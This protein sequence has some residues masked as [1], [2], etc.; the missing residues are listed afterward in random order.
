MTIALPRL[1]V[2]EVA[3]CT[4]ASRA[5]R[6]ATCVEEGDVGIEKGQAWVL[7]DVDAPSIANPGCPAE[8]VDGER[9]RDRLIGLH[10]RR[11]WQARSQRKGPGEHHARGRPRCR[12]R[13]DRGR[14]GSALAQQGKC[15]VRLVVAAAA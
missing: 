12:Q 2:A 8:R 9:A 13:A 10:G 15:L 5:D 7:L 4:P 14:S 3:A 11:Q 6:K 1:A